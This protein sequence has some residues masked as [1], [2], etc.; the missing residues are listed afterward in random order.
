MGEGRGKERKTNFVPG[1]SLGVR[2]ARGIKT[3]GQEI[4]KRYPPFSLTNK[5]KKK[6]KGRTRQ[7]SG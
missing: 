7:G 5:K 6:K 3:V 4:R 2:S 1:I